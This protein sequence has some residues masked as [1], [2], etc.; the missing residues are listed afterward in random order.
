MK[1]SIGLLLVLCMIYNGA[2]AQTKGV[3]RGSVKDKNT[4]EPIVGAV[5]AMD[6][7]TIASSSDVEGNYKLEVPVGTYNLKA[8]YL[9]YKA[10][11]QYNITSTSGNAQTINFELETSTAQ[12]NEVTVTYDKGKSAVAA[13][14]VTPMSTQK[15]TSEEIR[16]N[17][18]GNFDVSKVI[19]VLPGVSGGTSV[20]RNDIIVRG[21]APNEN[22]YYLDGIEIPVLNHF[23][24]QGA[25]GGAAGILNVS[26]IDDV[27]L[28][29]S[30]FD[31]RY[32]NALAS[33][34]V[35]KQRNGN[36][37]KF[38][39]NI[40]LSGTE[41]A[42][43]LEGPLGKRT[44]YLM[45][46]RRSYLQFLF[47][48]LDLPIRPDFWD[49]QYK[50]SHK[51]NDKASLNFIGIGAIDRFRLATPK[52]ASPENEYISRSNPLIDQWTYTVGVSL[53]QLIH[54]GYINVAL[55]RNAFNNGADKFQDNRNDEAFRT[56]K[57]RSQEVENKLRVDVNQFINGWKIGYGLMGQ[58]VHYQT[59]FFSNTSQG[60]KD[61][62]GNILVPP[63]SIRFNSELGFYKWGCFTQL[64]KRFFKEQVLLSMGLRADGNSFLNAGV[65]PANTLSPRLSLSY[66]L[67]PKI[68][69][70]ASVGRY[71]KIPVYTNLGYKDNSGVFVNR[72]MT[73]SN[74]MHYTLG[75]QY[76][77]KED[78][79]ITMEG[80][81]KKYSDY[82]VSSL[83]GISTANQGAEFTAV[84]N[85]PIQSIGKG[86]TYGVEVFIQ[87]KLVKKLF[88]A[89]STTVYKSE[90]SG[91][92]GILV[93][94]SWDY[95]YL[96][97]STLGYKFGKGWEV[98]LKYRV[99]G[100]QAY[101]PF[102]PAL[103]QANYPLIGVGTLDYSKINTLRLS[104]FQKLDFRLDKKI[105]LKKTTL[106]FY[107]DIQNVLAAPIPGLPRYTFKRKADNSD[108][109]TTD[110]NALRPDGAN[111]I[112]LLL[113]SNDRIVVPTLGFII[114]F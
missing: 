61:S 92:N 94:S 49:F 83:T 14:M 55:S 81:L 104:A 106:D 98:G 79:R 110:G 4:Q 51:L 2:A 107:V 77:P 10:L 32:D 88:Y 68:D 18:G 8:S 82:P 47:Q 71:F 27:Q 35:I 28:S 37:E 9:G 30:A 38:S 63:I 15:L 87:Q 65:N 57:L 13:D 52:N 85:E 66:A 91:S 41:F 45:S 24:T 97:S 36:P 100:G 62:L 56:L 19:Q 84:G 96:V 109:E 76:L 73:Y 20:N 69:I 5:I 12:L 33:T 3:I 114:E 1:T 22:V 86:T 42:T 26:F 25:S 64:S 53:K 23:Q 29:S 102:E 105:N 90:F 111:G 70:T 93:P 74:A 75:W 34:F 40:R 72:N 31:A 48:L 11:T 95:G 58:Y 43:T 80:F 54:K 60:L 103:S 21:G 16:A 99:S 59:D 113:E 89:F 108:F 6:G 112:P 101:T 46:A 39:G 78:L 7:T 67:F 50:L 17:P 44:N